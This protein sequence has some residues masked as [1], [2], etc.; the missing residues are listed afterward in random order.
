[1]IYDKPIATS[2]LALTIQAREEAEAEERAALAA[3]EPAPPIV[4][5]DERTQ[6][7]ERLAAADLVLKMRNVDALAAESDELERKRYAEIFE[8]VGK[9]FEAAALRLRKY[10]AN[11]DMP[12]FLREGSQVPLRTAL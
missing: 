4:L 12:E 9:Q 6:A 5:I 3:M 11:R 8:R 7:L 1:M 10:R 2:S